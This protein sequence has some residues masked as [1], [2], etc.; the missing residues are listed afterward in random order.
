LN[1]SQGLA[2]AL[3]PRF[4]HWSYTAACF[5]RNAFHWQPTGEISTVMSIQRKP[6]RFIYSGL[7]L[8]GLLCGVGKW[9]T[10]GAAANSRG[11]S[12]LQDASSTASPGEPSAEISFVALDKDNRAVR[13]L[14]PED[15]RVF[16][17]KTELKIKSVS[18]A[19]NEPLIIGILFDMSGS[20]RYDKF[21]P[22]EIRIAGEFAHSVWKEGDTGFVLAFNDDV[23]IGAEPTQRLEDIDQGLQK[24][25]AMRFRGSTALYDALC[26]AHPQD[27]GA[28]RGR[29][30]YIVFS[31]FD[32][33]T[34]HITSEKT[35]KIIK[36]AVISVFP[37][38]LGE[39]ITQFPSKKEDIRG[40][41]QARVF[42]E[43]TGGLAFNPDSTKE[44][45]N[46]A[47]ELSS[48]VQ[49]S[50]RVSYSISPVEGKKQKL[51]LESARPEVKILYLKH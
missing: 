23:Y 29:K 28:V 48:L 6:L 34:S 5:A 42:A 41:K 39:S 11:A 45:A 19:A 33:N 2:A 1:I 43:E 12:A 9:Q 40:R 50:Y 14:K 49:G 47:T 16:S 7:L 51:R 17:G 46:L 10:Q 13:D 32:D 20:R 18:S 3:V 37:V 35:I 36:Q 15:I 22:D 24:I 44:L 21:F 30:I 8:G 25:S 31:D 27:M 26:A 38:I 4:R